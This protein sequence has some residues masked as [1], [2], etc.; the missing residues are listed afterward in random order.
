[1]VT[2]VDIDEKLRPGRRHRRQSRQERREEY[3]KQTELVAVGPNLVV[4]IDLVV[5]DVILDFISAIR[6]REENETKQMVVMLDLVV[7]MDVSVV[8]S[9]EDNETRQMAVSTA[10]VVVLDV[11]FDDVSTKD[12]DHEEI[13]TK[14]MAAVPDLVVI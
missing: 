10:L 1:M 11:F 7:V 6:S 2:N 9:R 12:H 3:K 14:Q 13:E 5:I 4:V 8:R